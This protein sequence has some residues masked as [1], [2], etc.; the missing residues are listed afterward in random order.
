MYANV[1]FY[2]GSKSAIELA[3]TA[4]IYILFYLHLHTYVKKKKIESEPTVGGSS[5]RSR[6]NEVKKLSS[7]KD[8][9]TT[10]VRWN[11]T[12]NSHGSK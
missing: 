1:T 3:C 12:F 8:H 7:L 6:E 9:I 10:P 11:G 5:R 2:A 4:L